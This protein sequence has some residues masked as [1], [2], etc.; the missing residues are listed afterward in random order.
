MSGITIWLELTHNRT[1]QTKTKSPPFFLLLPTSTSARHHHRSLYESPIVTSRTVEDDRPGPE[2]RTRTVAPSL[3]RRTVAPSLQ[4]RTIA[5]SRQRRTTP[6]QWTGRQVFRFHSSQQSQS[7]HLSLYIIYIQISY[8]NLC[9]KHPTL[10]PPTLCP[11]IGYFLLLCFW[12]FMY[13]ADFVGLWFVYVLES[14][15]VTWQPLQC[16]Y[17]NNVFT[18]LYVYVC[19]SVC[20]YCFVSV[21]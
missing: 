21:C 1:L 12:Q 16:V 9:I 7:S 8:S 18:V 20:V 14:I 10:Y 13:K 11:S 4:Q 2:S 3:Q 15:Y 17:C 5:L 6:F 19:V